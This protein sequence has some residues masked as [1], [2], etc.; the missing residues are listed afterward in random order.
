MIWI[1]LNSKLLLLNFTG[2]EVAS[3]P[4]KRVWAAFFI[5]AA[6]SLGGMSASLIAYLAPDWNWIYIIQGFVFFFC[7]VALW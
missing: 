6:Y 1:I 3:T 2:L 7:L 4:A 5:S